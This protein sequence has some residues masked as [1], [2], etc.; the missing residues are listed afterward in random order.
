MNFDTCGVC[1]NDEPEAA[2]TVAASRAADNRAWR[3]QAEF[4]RKPTIIVGETAVPQ[5]SF[6]PFLTTTLAS[7]RWLAGIAGAFLALLSINSQKVKLIRAYG[8]P[9]SEALP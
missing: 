7:P 4:S 6:D 3:S 9:D 8:S 2:A 5:G 1:E